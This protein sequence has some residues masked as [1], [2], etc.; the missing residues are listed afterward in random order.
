VQQITSLNSNHTENIPLKQDECQND[1]TLQKNTTSTQE[2]VD[3]NSNLPI[4]IAII[5]QNIVNESSKSDTGVVVRFNVG[6]T[7]IVII[8]VLYKI[9]FLDYFFSRQ[10]FMN[11]LYIDIVFYIF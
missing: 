11:L 10:I 5:D 7:V 6:D 3:N 9:V 1:E 2:G 4:P 8:F